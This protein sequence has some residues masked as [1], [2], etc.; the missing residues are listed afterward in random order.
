V[1]CRTPAGTAGA[2]DVVVTDDSGP[3]TRTGGYTYV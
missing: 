2:R 1:S 3:V